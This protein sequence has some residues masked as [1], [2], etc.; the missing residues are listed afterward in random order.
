[1]LNMFKIILKQLKKTESKTKEESLKTTKGNKKSATS[2]SVW[3]TSFILIFHLFYLRFLNNSLSSAIHHQ[4]HCRSSLIDLPSLFGFATQ[5]KD[6]L[7][8]SFCFP[9]YKFKTGSTVFEE[10]TFS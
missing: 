5:N 1:M 6:I 10:N 2:V 4:N 9:M 8:E 7:N 3:N